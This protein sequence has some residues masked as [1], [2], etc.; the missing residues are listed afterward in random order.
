M[1]VSETPPLFRKARAGLMEKSE[2]GTHCFFFFGPPS[3]MLFE[4]LQL[5]FFILPDKRKRKWQR[6][7][8]VVYT[9]AY[10]NNGS[11]GFGHFPL[12]SYRLPKRA[13]PSS[14]TL[15][16]IKCFF[17]VTTLAIIWEEPE[18]TKIIMVKKKKKKRHLRAQHVSLMELIKNGRWILF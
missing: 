18:H 2:W 13:V 9:I 5:Q 8:L 6:A 12:A 14:R 4:I 1:M 10:E 7:S 17:V 3:F 11:D 16:I 15:L